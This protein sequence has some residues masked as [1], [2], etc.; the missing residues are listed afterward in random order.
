MEDSILHLMSMFASGRL[1]GRSEE[2]ALEFLA[3]YKG[4]NN[5]INGL[6]SAA[7]GPRLEARV[8]ELARSPD[9]EVRHGAIYFGLSTFADKS[10]AVID[11]LIAT[12]PEADTNNSERALWGLGH[13][14]S[15]RLQPKV[16]DALVELHNS[17]SNRGTR[18]ICARIVSNYGGVEARAR[19]S[20]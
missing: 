13:G 2:I 8:L 12:L 19:L 18:D 6:W 7:V 1:E 4:G 16:V 17:R 10:E 14:V 3:D 15:E 20:K 5:G 11:A 9:R